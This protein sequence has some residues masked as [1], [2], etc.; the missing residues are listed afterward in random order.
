SELPECVGVV[1]DFHT[2]SPSVRSALLYHL[3]QQ[4]MLICSD[5]KPSDGLEPSTHS[6]PLSTEPGSA[7]K[8]GSGRPEKSRKSKKSAE[9]EWPGVY[10]RARIGVPSVF[11]RIWLRM[12]VLRQ[13]H[14]PA[15]L[16][17]AGARQAHPRRARTLPRTGSGRSG[18]C[19]RVV[20]V[21]AAHPHL[22][23][24]VAALRRPVED[25]VVAHQELR[26]TGVAGVA[27]VD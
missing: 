1:A 10:G 25:R 7:G 12:R 16:S 26:A 27:V 22:R 17:R 8:R 9:D 20:L 21:V 15:D 2:P 19:S 24:L 23:A 11:P 18:G 5:F 6:L 13:R 3:R 14:G 4:S